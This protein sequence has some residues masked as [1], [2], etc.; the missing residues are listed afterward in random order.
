MGAPPSDRQLTIETARLRLEITLSG[1]HC[2]WFQRASAAWQ[3]L[4]MM[5][6]SRDSQIA[7]AP[8]E[9][10]YVV[11]RSGMAERQPHE[12]GNTTL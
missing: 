2:R 10:P 1:F 6:A 12:L 9:L 7:H 4:L 3:P 11:A 5:G 8:G